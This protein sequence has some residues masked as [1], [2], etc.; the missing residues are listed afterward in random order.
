MVEKTDIKT[1][2]DIKIVLGELW[3]SERLQNFGYYRCFR[4]EEVRHVISRMSRGRVTGPDE[5]L[6]EFWKSIDKNRA[7]PLYKNKGDIKN[8]NDYK[9]IKLLSH[10]Y[11][12]DLGESGGY[13]DEERCRCLEAKAV[14]MVYIWATKDMYDGYD[15][16]KIPNRT[17]LVLIPFLFALRMDE[18]TRSIQEEVPWCNL[19]VDDIKLIE[20]K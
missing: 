14:P 16:V 2:E 1:E 13:D 17:G 18:L 3:H 5:I 10:T 7:A 4:I 6:V 8:C 11:C 9:N 20:E 15:G 12:K 19:F